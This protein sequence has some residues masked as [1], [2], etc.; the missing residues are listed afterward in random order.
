[1]MKANQKNRFGQSIQIGVSGFTEFFRFAAFLYHFLRC[2]K[3]GAKKAEKAVWRYLTYYWSRI[4][5]LV[6]V[7][8]FVFQVGETIIMSA[9]RSF[10]DYRE[11]RLQKAEEKGRREEQD[12][13]RKWIEDGF[14]K[15]GIPEEQIQQIL[16]LIDALGKKRKD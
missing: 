2:M 9:Y 16:R 3:N 4:L 8:W 5:G 10:L 13:L 7:V 15:Q 6:V 1:M 14:R 12:R 11:R